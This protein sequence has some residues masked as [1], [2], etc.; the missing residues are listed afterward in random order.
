MTI[1][2]YILLLIAGMILVIYG[3]DLFVDSSIVIAKKTKIPTIIIGAT[4]VAVAT[5]LPELIVS[6][7]SSARGSFELAVGNAVG[8]VICNTALI[9][10]LSIAI[11]PSVLQ[12]KTSQIKYYLL[13]FSGF[14]LLAFGFSLTG[15]YKI[16]FWE[17]LIYLVLFVVYMVI[18][19]LD[20]KKQMTIN[21]QTNVEIKSKNKDNNI[22]KPIDSENAS[23]KIGNKNVKTSSTIIIFIISAGMIA[24]G[25]W[26]LVESATYLA[27]AIGISESF[28]GLTIVAIGTSLPELI[29]TITSIRK[30]NAALGYG[31][32]IGANILNIALI[33][34]VSGTIAGSGGLPIT[35]YTYLV[36]IP[37]A[38]VMLLIFIIPMLFKNKTYR[39]QGILLL[40]TYVAYIAFLTIMTILNIPV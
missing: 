9:S 13:L 32:I 18:N 25:A 29:T 14:L 23:L 33:M 34:G 7:I 39:W 27:T 10:G 28:I 20:A 3:G 5:T 37:V 26:L 40:G 11:I 1:F 12:E 4:I 2:L 16:S 30:K 6:V 31:N 17:A 38:I 8:S 21:N 35:K 24:L 22:E 36:S 19:V 15:D